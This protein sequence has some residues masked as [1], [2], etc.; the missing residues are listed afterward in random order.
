MDTAES[1]SFL[2][3]VPN[4]ACGLDEVTLCGS[5]PVFIGRS[6]RCKVRLP[7][8][9]L[10]VS[11]L[12]ATIA[13]RGS[14]WYVT[15]ESRSGTFINGVRLTHGEAHALTHGD[16]LQVGD[17][18][19]GVRI[20]TQSDEE[21][22]GYTL[23]EYQVDFARVDVA[24]VL[25]AA[26]E[27]PARLADAPD[28]A[29]IHAV[30]C[31]YLVEALNPVISL[32]YVTIV[33][34]TSASVVAC[35]QRPDLF[36]GSHVEIKPIVS[37]R[38]VRRLLEAPESV[39]FLARG[40]NEPSFTLPV[41]ATSTALGAAMLE[42]ESP[43][44]HTILY[45]LGDVALENVKLVAPYLRLTATLIRQHLSTQRRAHLSKYF[46]PQI[47]RLLTQRGAAKALEGE[48]HVA[49]GTTL[50]FDVRGSSLPLNSS[51][52]Q[53]ANVYHDLRQILSI[54]TETIF[55]SQGTVIDYAGDAVLAVWGIPFAQDDHADRAV[56]SALE[57]VR[58]LSR[59]KLRSL[60][61]GLR[62]G[63]LGV[64]SGEMLVGPVGSSSVFK[65]GVF[66]PTVNAAQRISCLT[67][68]TALGRPI[69]MTA[70]VK[71]QLVRYRCQAQRVGTVELQGMNS[72]VELYE[73]P[74]ELAPCEATS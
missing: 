31:R 6:S 65:Y 55:E 38:L 4:Q 8:S 37:R 34:E 66:G 29:D 10:F 69:L 22:G 56:G 12:H 70:S 54:V 9:S 18:N 27:L 58:R 67:K 19:L 15:D 32:A 49:Y 53:L 47:L 50:F 46:S 2:T 20:G 72:L 7:E 61:A 21:N 25:R 73:V 45:A 30:A 43:S 40:D 60:R 24:R 48:P 57:I 33:N 1:T 41:D 3:L 35:A 52:A 23:S 13:L 51:S 64:A 26:L 28:E 36:D 11:R 59:A 68:T 42:L 16:V 63:G 62:I 44:Q 17:L 14:H 5:E 39:L 71:E 74:L